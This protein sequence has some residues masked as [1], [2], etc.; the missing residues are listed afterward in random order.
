MNVNG[1]FDHQTP[2]K[3]IVKACCVLT[4]IEGND[5]LGVFNEYA[6]SPETTGSIHSKLQ[7]TA[8]G[9]EVDDKP[10]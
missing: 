4:D 8:H 3:Q 7:L 1:I 5:I 9:I 10:V 2:N 6:Y